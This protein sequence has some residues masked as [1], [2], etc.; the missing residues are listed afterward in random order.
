MR[1]LQILGLLLIAAPFLAI[2][3]LSY[4]LVGAW[5]TLAIFGATAL[6]CGMVVLGVNLA[7][8]Q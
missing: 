1:P 7:N 4:A 5:A 3:G 6:I 2:A 8:A